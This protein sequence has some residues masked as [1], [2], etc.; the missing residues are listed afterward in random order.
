MKP[1]HRRYSAKVRQ[2]VMSQQVLPM[3]AFTLEALG[4]LEASFATMEQVFKRQRYL[5]DPRLPFAFETFKSVK[6]K[7]FD[8]LRA[9]GVVFEL[10]GNEVLI[11]R[12]CLQ[13]Y[14][15]DLLCMK[16]TPERLKQIAVC[17]QVAAIL[18]KELS[19][20]VRLHD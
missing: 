9:P 14:T 2:P 1:K 18:P 20:P 8:M 17:E 13:V 5:I 11:I 10:D 3:T 4:V 7:V 12:T 19:S 15:I 6:Q 16:A